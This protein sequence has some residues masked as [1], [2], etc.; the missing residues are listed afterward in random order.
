[1]VLYLGVLGLGD[2][3][4]MDSLWDIFDPEEDGQC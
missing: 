4:V 1:M 2:E 3:S